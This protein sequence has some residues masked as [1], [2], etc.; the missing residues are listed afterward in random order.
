MDYQKSTLNGIVV[1]FLK[2]I[3]MRFDH[4]ACDKDVG[5]YHQAISHQHEFCQRS[6]V[7]LPIL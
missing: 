6:S 1:D 7:Y 3:I 5:H 2:T 4:S